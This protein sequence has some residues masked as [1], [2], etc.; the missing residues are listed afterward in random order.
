MASLSLL[1]DH[2]NQLIC[3]Q[4]TQRTIIS[5]W[6]SSMLQKHRAE[7]V[8]LGHPLPFRRCY[9]RPP[10]QMDGMHSIWQLSLSDW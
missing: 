10:I 9:R 2:Q 8:V 4:I 7:V 1:R 6:N 3:P 5:T